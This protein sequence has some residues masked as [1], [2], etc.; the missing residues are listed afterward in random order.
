MAMLNNQRVPV[1]EGQLKNEFIRNHL[2]ATAVISKVLPNNLTAVDD[3]QQLVF[4]SKTQ[5]MGCWVPL[6]QFMNIH[7]SLICLLFYWNGQLK[8]KTLSDF[9]DTLWLRF[10]LQTRPARRPGGALS[11]FASLVASRWV[12]TDLWASLGSPHQSW[13]VYD[14]PEQGRESQ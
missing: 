5:T 7:P 13:T 4:F 6:N 10:T 9:S 1:L 14:L 3:R 8:K 2:S 11:C 12:P